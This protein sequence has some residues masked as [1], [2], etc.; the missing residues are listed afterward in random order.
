VVSEQAAPANGQVVTQRVVRQTAVPA[1]TPAAVHTQESEVYTDDPYARNRARVYNVQQVI[2]LVFG[3]LEGLLALRFVLKLLGANPH[4][5]FAS[6]IYGITAPFMAPFIGVFGEPS[7]GGS[8]VEF[9]ALVAIAV[10]ALISWVL[11]KVV[12]LVAGETRR[13]VR[14][15]EVHRRIDQ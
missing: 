7:A 12:W 3:I 5:G 8:V 10:Y 2:Y 14:T 1:S 9:N 11:V 13:G 15:S 4:S 6:F